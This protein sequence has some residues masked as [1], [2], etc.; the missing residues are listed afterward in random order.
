MNDAD[1]GT[2]SALP[3]MFHA[4]TARARRTT[5]SSGMGKDATTR[6]RASY[7]L[8][9]RRRGATRARVTDE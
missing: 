1:R 5:S 6:R 8:A 3:S 7:A 9:R 2:A 4:H